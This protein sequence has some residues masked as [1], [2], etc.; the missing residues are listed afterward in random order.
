MPPFN[1]DCWKTL[2]ADTSTS[3]CASSYLVSHLKVGVST[4][5]YQA[6]PEMMAAFGKVSFS[7]DFLNQTILEM[8]SK[9]IDGPTMARQF[10]HDHPEMWKP[11]VPNDVAQKVQAS[12][13]GA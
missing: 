1:A 12:L 13:T 4:P 3:Q 10:L 6:E 7:M 2:R 9:K 5:F 11:W 8:T